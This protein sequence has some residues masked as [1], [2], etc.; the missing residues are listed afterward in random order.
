M[1]NQTPEAIAIRAKLETFLEDV[2]GVVG[3]I[4]YKDRDG[5]HSVELVR[6]EW[7]QPN[8]LADNLRNIACEIAGSSW[9]AVGT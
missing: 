2:D 6:D 9:T 1:A 7:V 8:D 4:F 3:V 5:G